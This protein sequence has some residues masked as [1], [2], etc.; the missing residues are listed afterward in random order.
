MSR[1]EK[2]R[3]DWQPEW[4]DEVGGWVTEALRESYMPEMPPVEDGMYLIDI[5]QEF[6]PVKAGPMSM[7]PIEVVDVDA[8]CRRFVDLA[9][10]ETRWL[11]RMSQAYASELSAA[12]DP[13]R[14]PPWMPDPDEMTFEQRERIAKAAKAALRS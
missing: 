12:S 3:Q 4:K 13:Q 14:P 6:G 2:L 10:W 5:L 7:V 8:Y 9:P 1:L 11:L